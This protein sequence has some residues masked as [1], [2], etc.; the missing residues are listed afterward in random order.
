MEFIEDSNLLKNYLISLLES[1]NIY[2]LFKFA[3]D[4]NTV[5][6]RFGV[7]DEN[8]NNDCF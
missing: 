3:I 4:S 2:F 6:D 5:H 1:G 8:Y 7:I